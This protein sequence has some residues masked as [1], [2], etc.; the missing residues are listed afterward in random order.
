MD[1]TTNMRVLIAL[2]IIALFGIITFALVA[3][4]LGT[5]NQ[6]YDRLDKQ[7]VD[8]MGQVMSISQTPS[9]TTTEVYETSN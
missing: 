7:I 1:G 3:A 2:G 9:T 8:L 4:T 6:R 5:L